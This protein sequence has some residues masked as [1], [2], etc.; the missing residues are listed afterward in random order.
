MQRLS[1]ITGMI[2][3]RFTED[4]FIAENVHLLK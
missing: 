3:E 2:Q 4:T 1:D